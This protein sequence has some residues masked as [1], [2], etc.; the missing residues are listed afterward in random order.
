VSFNPDIVTDYATCGIQMGSVQRSTKARNQWDSA[1]FEFPA[2]GFVDL[3]D[4]HRGFSLIC[5][6]KFGYSV[7][8]NTVEMALL[9]SPADVDPH[10]DLG[11]QEYSYAFYCHDKPYAEAKVAENSDAF[12]TALYSCASSWDL[13]TPFMPPFRFLG[14][15]L[16]IKHIKPAE[17]GRGIILRCYEPL[18]C[19]VTDWLKTWDP[20]ARITKCNMLE[21]EICE[22]DPDQ[23]IQ[24]KAFEIVTLRLEMAP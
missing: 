7:Q 5:P 1:R 24:A 20:I 22:L 15:S 12:G 3:S 4:A 13:I 14:G 23:P 2:Q 10:A 18:G 8:E 9:R 16:I 6:E 17:D 11:S 21:E 19:A